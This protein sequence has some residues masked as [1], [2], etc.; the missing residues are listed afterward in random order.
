MY[1]MFE[2][3]KK[4][5]AE[6]THI[7]VIQ[8]ENP[9][10]DSVASSVALEEIFGDMGKKVT[11]YC[12]VQIG[13]YLGYI[14]GWDRV[15]DE[16]PRDFDL[17]VIVDTASA[18]LLERALTPGNLAQ[19]QAHPNIVIDHHTTE[20]TI[21]FDHV[22]V[23][24]AKKVATG[25]LIYEMA[26]ANEWPLNKQACENLAISIMADSLGLI[27]ENTTANSVRTVA[28]L[29][30]GGA[31]LAEIDNR[32]R[33]FMKKAPEILA[34]KGA[35]LQRVEYHADGQ[36]ALVHIPWEEI[37]KYSSK[38]NPSMLVIDEMRLVEGV[39]LAICVKTYPDGKITG[40]IRA[41]SGYKVA[42]TIAKFFGGGGHPYVA[43]FRTYS[44]NYDEVKAELIGAVDK[45][46]MEHKS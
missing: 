9:D 42:E 46:L 20:G 1:K 17:S 7:V 21:P 10:G 31:S 28:A 12:P 37:S 41:N 36:L 35:L 39:K 44:D 2:Q 33:E 3:A 19:L 32:R 45:V 24:D 6:A 30:D 5:V 18:T 26:I 43:G 27:T 14:K 23:T 25:E 29:I 40:K 13:S 11:M 22:A 15:V 16:L 38:Y 8:A 34:Y 4:L